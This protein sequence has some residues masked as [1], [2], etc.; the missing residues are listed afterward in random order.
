MSLQIKVRPQWTNETI[1]INAFPSDSLEATLERVNQ[2]QLHKNDLLL[3]YTF[4]S[5]GMNLNIK[6]T[7]EKNK[8]KNNDTIII[9]GLNIAAPPD[10]KP[11]PTSGF[12]KQLCDKMTERF[13]VYEEYLDIVINAC[14][15]PIEK[16]CLEKCK[17]DCDWGKPYPGGEVERKIKGGMY[18]FPPSG[19]YVGIALKVKDDYYNDEPCYGY[20]VSYHGV[21]Y[22]KENALQIVG[23]IINGTFKPGE[24]QPHKDKKD[25]N[26]KGQL[27]GEGIYLNNNIQYAELRASEKSRYKGNFYKPIIECRVDK[28]YLKIP[29]DEYGYEW[30]VEPQYIKATMILLKKFIPKI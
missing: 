10:N 14:K 8:I 5:K 4:V 13:K 15:I 20:S 1:T 24:G 16:I 3:S 19:G 23:L 18:Y 30:V 22:D 26:H 21:G 25:F 12:Y 28:K 7:L 29:E 11:Q 6:E 27:V 17:M 2:Q 9:K